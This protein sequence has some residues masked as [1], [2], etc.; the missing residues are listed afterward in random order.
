MGTRSGGECEL[1]LKVKPVGF[2]SRLDVGCEREQRKK[3]PR[4]G[5]KNLGIVVPFSKL[6]SRCEGGK[7]SLVEHLS[8]VWG[9][10][11]GA[12][13]PV[14]CPGLRTL[15]P[16]PRGVRKLFCGAELRPSWVLILPS[17]TPE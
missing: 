2:A 16:A 17:R 8:G 1:H 12:W 14:Q 4:F 15:G 7:V 3:P 13:G 9:A 10:L 11:P 5:P 6:R